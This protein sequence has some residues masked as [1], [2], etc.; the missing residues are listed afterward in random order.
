MLPHSAAHE[1]GSTAGIPTKIK[2]QNNQALWPGGHERL[3]WGHDINQGLAWANWAVKTHIFCITLT[4]WFSMEN[5]LST[6][7]RFLTQKRANGSPHTSIHQ[8][9]LMFRDKQLNP[10]HQR[11]TMS[12]PKW[13]LAREGTNWA[14][15]SVL[16]FSVLPLPL[17]HCV[18]E[19]LCIDVAMKELS[20]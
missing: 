3:L 20:G 19:C 16:G 7:F 17:T 11:K 2:L 13:N 14:L 6:M 12:C 9:S 4:A 15:V 8:F 1:Q 18:A 10:T 5:K